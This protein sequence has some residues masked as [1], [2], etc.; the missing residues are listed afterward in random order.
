MA[1]ERIKNVIVGS[2][3]GGKYLA[4]HLA[5]AGEQT[6]VVERKWIGGACPNTNCLPSKNEIWSAK[7][8]SLIDHAAQFGA[9]P[10]PVSIDMTAVLR[11]KREMV[12][13]LIKI[14]LDRYKATGAEL[15]M[16]SATFTAPRTLHVQLND[17]GTRTLLGERV[18]LNLGTRAALP[19]TPGLAEARPLTHIEMLELD[20]VPQHLIVIGG[21]YVGLE[22][23][24]AYR[25]FRSRVTIIQHNSQLLAGQDADVVS[26]VSRILAADGIEIITSAEI[27]AVQGRSG[28]G[29]RLQVRTPERETIIEGTDI[30]VA[31]GRTP[32]T[33]GIGLELAGVQTDSRGYLKVNERLE[34]TAPQVWAIGECAGSPQFTHVSQDDFRIIRDNLAGKSRTTRDRVIPS[35]LFID[36]QVAHIGLTE[37]DAKRSG[38]A[39][40]IAKLPTAAV[41]RTRTID[42]T[43]GFIKALIDPK[44][45]R[46]L[47]FTMIGP[48][49]GEVMG[50]VQIAMLAG[51]PFTALRDAIFAHPTM[52]E[53]LNAL[54][55]SIH[56]AA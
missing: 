7:V 22:F 51:L 13:G 38:L 9:N 49:A 20:D 11:R 50:V 40:R 34:T 31:A 45:D 39:V 24:Q 5:E 47:G 48:E 1:C 35:C 42:E 52:A 6:F 8:V 16:G 36:P 30:L 55:A 2:G 18:F 32:N 4:W 23:A 17:G 27:I 29:V 26:D 56:P 3:E 37:N 14:H 41:L 46:I 12:D 44:N 10:G 33:G 43:V 53:G 54:F 28:A 21:G 25:R 15:I 19:N